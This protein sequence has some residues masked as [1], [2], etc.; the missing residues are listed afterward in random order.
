M[1]ILIVKNPTRKLHYVT[2]ALQ[3]H[4]LEILDYKPGVKFNTAGKDLVILSGGGGEGR[5]VGDKHKN[6]QLF[7]KD[8]IDF[9]LKCDKPILGICLGF[10]LIAHAH[11]AKIKKLDKGLEGLE[12]IQ[13]KDG[14]E[15]QQISSRDFYVPSVP[16]EHFEVLAESGYGIEMIKHKTR[17]IIATQF[18]P[19]R[20]GTISLANL[21]SSMA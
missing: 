18:H 3:G 17:P 9:I 20:G 6:G 7:Y 2:T 13:L 21:I 15:V 19:E 11:G 16:A 14:R 12:P 5:E 8:E 10:E 4:Q 1:K